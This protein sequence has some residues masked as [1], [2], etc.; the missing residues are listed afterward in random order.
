MRFT[1]V[2]KRKIEQYIDRKMTQE[3]FE[4]GQVISNLHNKYGYKR[5]F[6]ARVN[7]NKVM[8]LSVDHFEEDTGIN[9]FRTEVTAKN[10]KELEFQL[11][12]NVR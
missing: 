2:S 9:D 8:T 10:S 6:T 4:S 7:D 3:E 1:K 12:S 11:K 5:V